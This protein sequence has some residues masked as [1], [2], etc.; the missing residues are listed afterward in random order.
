MVRRAISRRQFLGRSACQAATVAAGVVSLAATAQ[1]SPNDRIGV[2]VIGVRNRGR[3]L[4]GMLAQFGDVSV[5]SLCDVDA[6]VLPGAV[7]AVIEQGAA[8]PQCE[9]DARRLFDDP[10]IDA[11]VIATPD[12][13]HARLTRMACEAGKDVY[14]ESPVTWRFGE[15]AELIR[16]ARESRR[17]IQ[18]GVQERSSDAIQAA[19]QHVRQDRLGKVSL[20]KAWTV[21]RR[22]PIPP[23][24]DTAPPDDFDYAAWLADAPARPFNWNRVHFNWRWHWDYGGGELTHWGSHWLD[25]ARRA[26]QADWPQRITATGA[27]GAN[28]ST[29]E[30]PETLSVHYHCGDIAVLWEHRLGSSHGV[31]GRSSGVAFYGE[32]GVLVV[33]RGGWKV[34]DGE[35]AHGAASAVQMQTAHLRN[36]IDCVRTRQTP[37]ADVASCVTSAGWC[38]LGNAA[39][40]VERE[41][42]FDAERQVCIDDPQAQALL[43]HPA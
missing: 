12:H 23:K 13:S 35:T 7:A 19:V 16:V 3:E 22:K 34:Y 2:G 15:G 5:R 11:V 40:R 6:S 29:I 36:F 27:R 24:P 31:E 41:L 21:H 38:H 32:H 18:C 10:T 33:D 8:T 14:V 30:T 9:H 39:Y 1:G 28:S 26:L 25:V 20:V 43:H 37:A 4:A 17:V 42:R